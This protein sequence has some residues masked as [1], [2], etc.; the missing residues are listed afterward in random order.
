VL[1]LKSLTEVTYGN[2]VSNSTKTGSNTDTDKMANKKPIETNE[3]KSK[4]TTVTS[5]VLTALL[6]R[7]S[8]LPECHA[9]ANW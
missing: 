2:V 1:F 4:C 6:L 3:D 8:G 7:D 5:E 9:G